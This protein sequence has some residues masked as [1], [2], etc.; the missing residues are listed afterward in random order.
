ME[1]PLEHSAEE[2]KRLQRCMNDLVS[3]L[4][5]P[6]IWSGGGPTQVVD[7]LLDALLRILR[8]DLV[9]VQLKESAGEAPL[10]A[11]RV[12]PSCN[13]TPATQ[14]LC[15]LLKR[16]LEHD[17]QTWPALL[18][19][20]FGD[21]DLAIVPCRLGLNGE[22]GVITAGSRRADFPQES[23]RLLLNVAANQ[24]AVGLQGAWL[25]SE[26]KRVATELDQRIAQRTAELAA[27]N[28]KLRLQAAL[29][30]QIPVAAWTV[31]TDG[32]PD[33]VN[34]NWLEY[35]GQALEFVQSAPEAWMSAIHP[36]D[37][38]RTAKSFWDGIAS[39]EGFTMEARFRRGHDG[40]YRWHLNR[41][42][43]LRDA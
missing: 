39:G 36:D 3:I 9:Y 7:T 24:A 16:E 13:G 22:I 2:I 15:K 32:I 17:P 28:E 1:A 18:R 31:A 43:A 40:I 38:E 25:L 21:G 29:L 23:E 37:Q 35:T 6:A 5:L 33:F 20:P 41:A 26:Q 14:A 34:Q 27:A 30:Q 19:N 42:V 8:L 12:G 11:V 4:A 10:E